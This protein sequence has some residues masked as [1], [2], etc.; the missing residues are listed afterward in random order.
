MPKNTGINCVWELIG[1]IHNDATKAD[2]TEWIRRDIVKFTRVEKIIRGPEA[3]DAN[4]QNPFCAEI[5][6]KLPI[7]HEIRC[8]FNYH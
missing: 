6:Q 2:C 1:G 8:G 4:Y 5:N 7:Q 3:Y